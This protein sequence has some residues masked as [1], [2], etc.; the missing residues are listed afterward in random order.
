MSCDWTI[1]AGYGLLRENLVKPTKYHEFKLSEIKGWL[2]KVTG[3][4]VLRVYRSRMDN[5]EQ[6]EFGVQVVLI[7]CDTNCDSGT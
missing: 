5:P 7:T 1:A 3:N 6:F 2:V 4:H